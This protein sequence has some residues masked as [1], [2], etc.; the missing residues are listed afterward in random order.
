MKPVAVELEQEVVDFVR[1]LP[2][3]PRQALRRALKNLELEQGDIRALEGLVAQ[4]RV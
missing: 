2:P 3:Q 1:S 4:F